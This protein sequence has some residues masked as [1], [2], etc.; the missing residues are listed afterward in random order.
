MFMTLKRQW[1]ALDGS[2]ERSDPMRKTS[3]PAGRH[4]IERIPCPQLNVTANWFV[5]KGT[6][7]GG[8]EAFWRQWEGET[9]DMQVII[10]E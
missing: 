2:K 6:K 1:E 5:L 10:E 4:E 8:A 9:D 7:I 3:I